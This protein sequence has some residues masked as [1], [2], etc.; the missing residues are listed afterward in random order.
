MSFGKKIVLLLAVLLCLSRSVSL[1]KDVIS[2]SSKS[3]GNSRAFLNSNADTYLVSNSK[4]SN[5]G[6]YAMPKVVYRY[7]YKNF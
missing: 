3:V 2:S 4:A 7:K 1:R 6:V 5:Y